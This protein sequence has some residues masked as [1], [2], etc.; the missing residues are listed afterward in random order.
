MFRILFWVKK[1]LNFCNMTKISAIS[2]IWVAEISAI[3]QKFLFFHIQNKIPN[4]FCNHHFSIS[5]LHHGHLLWGPP[6]RV[7]C[8]FALRFR[9]ILWWKL[10][11]F[12]QKAWY[13]HPGWPMMKCEI[14]QFRLHVRLIECSEVYETGKS[15]LI[16]GSIST[17]P[18]AYSILADFGHFS[19]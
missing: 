16:P 7:Q 5:H 10:R 2:N 3:S 15:F 9:F 13:C 1:N 19:A 4:I 12:G 6:I 8:T 11:I 17:P 14:S 18:R